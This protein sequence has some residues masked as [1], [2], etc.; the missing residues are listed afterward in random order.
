MR[1]IDA[2]ALIN[3]M[4]KWYFDKEKQDAAKADVSPMDLFTNLAITTVREQ[5]TAYDRDKVIG[6]LYGLKRYENKYDN[7]YEN[8]MYK[9]TEYENDTINSAIDDAIKIVNEGGIS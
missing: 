3:I 9:M 2:D 7:Y 5:P 6:G 8:A 1:M 4:K